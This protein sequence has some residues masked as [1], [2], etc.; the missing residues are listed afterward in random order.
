MIGKSSEAPIDQVH[1][2]ESN[3]ILPA[4]VCLWACVQHMMIEDGWYETENE[5]WPM[6]AGLPQR[7]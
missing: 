7:N 6:A 2:R 1:Q 4:A 3:D 5:V